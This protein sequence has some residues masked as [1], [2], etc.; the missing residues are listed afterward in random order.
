MAT[1]PMIAAVLKPPAVAVVAVAV[2]AVVEVEV[3]AVPPAAPLVPPYRPAT[4]PRRAP[5]STTSSEIESLKPATALG[6]LVS[7]V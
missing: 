4:A 7:S 2:V 1:P 5:D 3:A 6:A